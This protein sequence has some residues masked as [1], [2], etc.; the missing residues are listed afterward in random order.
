MIIDVNIKKNNLI[1]NNYLFIYL[2]S[3]EVGTSKR[4]LN[5]HCASVGDCA[6]IKFRNC[7]HFISMGN[8]IFSYFFV[9]VWPFD[10]QNN[11]LHI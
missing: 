3:F 6:I 5:G 4:K 8:N 11:P 10:G 7:L 1:S 2:F 9:R